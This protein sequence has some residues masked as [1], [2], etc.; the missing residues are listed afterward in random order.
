MQTQQ[1]AAATAAIT[2]I[3]ETPERSLIN[4]LTDTTAVKLSEMKVL[5]EKAFLSLMSIQKPL[6]IAVAATAVTLKKMVK[7]HGEALTAKLICA[8]LK[9][10]NDSLNASQ[11]MT[12]RQLFECADLFTETFPHDTLKDLILCLKRAKMGHY[13]TDYNRIDSTV[14]TRFFRA[15]LDEKADWLEQQRVAWN[16]ELKRSTPGLGNLLS[17]AVN[18]GQLTSE[19]AEQ[20][21]QSLHRLTQKPAGRTVLEY[22]HNSAKYDQWLTENAHEL[23]M[24]LLRKIEE[25]ARLRNLQSTLAI[26]TQAINLR[27][28]GNTGGYITPVISYQPPRPMRT[29]ASPVIEQAFTA[30][31]YDSALQVNAPHMS[32]EALQDV[33]RQA[34][35]RGADS[36]L[37]I[38]KNELKRRS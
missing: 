38:V 21:R 27:L 26:V 10:Y 29:K 28:K 6:T 34:H 11:Q 32:L 18:E 14:V 31:E 25:Q 1:P 23:E 20:V 16:G 12:A 36:T 30:E 15:Y 7:E 17:E 37:A 19:Q 13:G 3:K 24:D 33:G 22:A 2:V 9:L 35:Q 8:V 4:S 5:P